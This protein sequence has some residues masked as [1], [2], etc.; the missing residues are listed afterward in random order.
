MDQ[1][2]TERTARYFADQI[3]CCKQRAQ[4]LA[5][6]DR[7]DEAVFAKIEANVYEIFNSVFSVAVHS[8]GADDLTLAGFF[9]TRIQQIPLNWQTALENAKEHGEVEKAHIEQLKLDTVAAIK[10]AFEQI[11]EVD[12]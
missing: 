4:A 10:G 3:S 12:P 1:Q 6:D 8:A 5:R 2:K 9:L 11:W 7:T